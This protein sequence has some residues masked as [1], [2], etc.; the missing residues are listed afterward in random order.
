MKTE[1]C[2][3]LEYLIGVEK[4]RVEARGR[5]EEPWW[6]GLSESVWLRVGRMFWER[7]GGVVFL[8]GVCHWGW[9]LMF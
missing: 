6:A 7:S 3:D 9:D 4:L 1:S 8:N 5:K 2:Y